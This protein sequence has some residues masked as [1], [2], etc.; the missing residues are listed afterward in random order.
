MSIITF[1]SYKGGVGRSMALANVAVLLARQGRRVLV[2]DWDLEAPGIEKYFTDLRIETAG[3][4]LLPMLHRVAAGETPDYTD[5]TWKVTSPDEA[6]TFTFLQSGRETDPEYFQN[7]ERFSWPDFF[8]RQGGN[9]LEALRERWL[10]EFDCVLIDS[11]TGLSDAGGV[12]TI[13][14]PDIIVALFTPARQSLFGV[15]DVMRLAKAARQRLA[16]DREALSVVPVPSR[17]EATQ[18][19]LADWMTQFATEMNEFFADWLPSTTD[20]RQVLERL[21]L[22]HTSNVSH[23]EQLAVLPGRTETIGLASQYEKLA[24]ILASDLEDLSSVVSVPSPAP[25]PVRSAARRRESEDYKYDLYMSYARSELTTEWMEHH[26]VPVLSHWVELISGQRP[27]IF[28]DKAV[29]TAAA[30]WAEVQKQAL[31][32][33]R[34]LIPVLSPSYFRSRWCRAEFETFEQR[35]KGGYA[36]LLIPVVISGGE[37]FPRE[38]QKYQWADF[39]D[40]MVPLRQFASSPR[41]EQFHDK[42]KR[43]AQDVVD[44]LGHVPSYNPGWPLV[45]PSDAEVIDPAVPRFT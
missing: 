22:P 3:L 4:G 31:S 26:F 9:F 33:S 2:V 7:L 35:N 44:A 25:A 12:C 38:V 19:S 23:G 16:F 27:S 15:R 17:I 37:A 20:R 43:L 32:R 29:L 41:Y 13:Q 21:A 10:A 40:E 18:A 42:V 14:L 8:A 1:Y 30:E 39:R 6:L 5:F 11:R 28:F 45:N 24:S 36:S 34:L